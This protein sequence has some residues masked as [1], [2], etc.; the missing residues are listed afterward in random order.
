MK[1]R[2]FNILM[3]IAV[4]W[5]LWACQKEELKE[6]NLD[7]A[8]IEL[9]LTMPSASD[10]PS[11]RNSSTQSPDTQEDGTN[12]EN[13]LLGVV[14][15][16]VF[17]FDQ[18]DLFIGEATDLTLEHGKTNNAR[19]IWGQLPKKALG[20]SVHMVLMANYASRG[21]IISTPAPFQT[22]SEWQKM[23]TFM[24]GNILWNANDNKFLPLSGECYPT[25]SNDP[26]IVN[27]ETIELIRAIAKV[28]IRVAADCT[29]TVT[30][31]H[32]NGAKD[33]SFSLQQNPFALPANRID[34][35]CFQF[36]NEI[37]AEQVLE[38]YLPEQSANAIT[39]DL[40]MSDGEN[41]ENGLIE[42]KVYPDGACYPVLR[43]FIYE[44]VV[45]KKID[46]SIADIQLDI[47]PWTVYDISSDYE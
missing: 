36:S 13:T 28:R 21:A 2:L 9:C 18:N 43:N 32:V 38:F 46:N 15:M 19:Y 42:F 12:Y 34:M 31:L 5:S 47:L 35:A 29:Y 27:Q 39:M 30:S 3:V 4:G 26:A 45:S 17:V 14:D 10:M 41:T 37:K 11:S 7:D 40:T 16:R 33:N 44:F 22:Y 24:Y 1:R 23:Q 8:M 6:N 25:I 20:Q